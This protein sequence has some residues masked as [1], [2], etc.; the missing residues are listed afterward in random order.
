VRA[1]TDSDADYV[2]AASTASE[3]DGHDL[4]ADPTSSRARIGGVWVRR[5]GENEPRAE[6]SYRLRSPEGGGATLRIEE[7]GAEDSR[8]DILVDGA[9]IAT[10]GAKPEQ[11]GVYGGQ[12]GLVHYDVEL[13]RLR[14]DTFTLTFRNAGKPGPGARIAGVWVQGDRGDIDAPYGGTV[15]NPR[16]LT[17]GRGATELRTDLF[18][19][20][21]VIYDF[22]REVG[23]TVSV[24]AERHSRGDRLAQR[25]EAGR[26]VPVVRAGGG[27]Q[28]ASGL[29]QR[30]GGDRR[31]AGRV[32]AQHVDDVPRGMA[33]AGEDDVALQRRR[34]PGGAVVLRPHVRPAHARARPLATVD[35]RAV[36]ERLVRARHRPAPDRQVGREDPLRREPASG[37]QIARLDRRPQ[38]R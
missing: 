4:D 28:V 12:V 35:Q 33:V 2:T 19:R 24:R 7:A 26:R 3:A 27:H 15:T 22:G 16:A 13:P 32:H 30:V 8:Y 9:R 37:G 5:A 17:Q 21:Y 10:R 34:P 29:A 20:P 14:R 36:A 31:A 11:R 23:G 18:G 25:G 38:R 6:F 1:A